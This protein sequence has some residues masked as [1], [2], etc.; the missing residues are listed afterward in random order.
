MKFT[1]LDA[2]DILIIAFIIYK[3][4]DVIRGTRAITLLKG[5]AV[6]F[7]AS[8][9]ARALS[10][11][12]VSWLLEQSTTAIF[13]ALPVVFYPEL[14]RALEQLGSGR[15]FT[16]H[17]TSKEQ[18]DQLIETLAQVAKDLSGRKVGALV[19]IERDTGLQEFIE[20]GVQLDAVLSTQLLVNIFE[21]NSPLHDGAVM[22][23]ANRIQAASCVLPLTETKLDSQLGTRHRAAVGLTEHSDAL[24]VVVSEETGAISLA[25]GGRLRRYLTVSRLIEQLQAYLHQSE[26][27]SLLRRVWKS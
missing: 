10:L 25:V 2:I 17:E 24:V 13:V 11:R 22:V 9:M 19:A 16:K 14:R 20:T 7:V 26:E 8:V 1:V 3:L 18:V 4:M 6:I 5:L 15:L 23:R 12:T 27:P 21:P